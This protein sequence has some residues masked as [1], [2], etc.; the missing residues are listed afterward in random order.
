MRRSVTPSLIFVA[1]LLAVVAGWRIFAATEAT[2]YTAT[3]R[4]AQSYSVIHLRLTLTHT[5]GPI[6]Q[7]VYAMQNIN[8]SSSV[9]YTATNRRGTTARFTQAIDRYDVTFLFE[10]LVADGIWELDS[11][12][13]RGDTTTLYDV[14]VAQAIGNKSGSREY[15]FTDPHY[16][17]TTGGQQFQIHLDPNKPVPDLLTLKSTS[18]EEPRFE[19]VIADFTSFS[20]P[21]FRKTV[22]RA[23][24]SAE[25]G[26]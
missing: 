3:Q 6:A 7:E 12:P 10:R 4:V 1:I 19:R 17:A 15:H 22:A 20:P 16:W 9:T 25:R 2:R 8:G 26:S 24:T 11:K 21:R 5:T 14:R 23:R 18:I 13:P